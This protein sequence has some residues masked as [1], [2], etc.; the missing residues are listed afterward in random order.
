MTV[1]WLATSDALHQ[2]ALQ[3]TGEHITG[4]RE[5]QVSLLTIDE[6]IYQL[7]R[8]MIAR[9]FGH[10]TPKRINP[11]MVMKQNPTLLAAFRPQIHMAIS[12]LLAWGTLT[13]CAATA[14]QI[15]DSWLERFDDIGGL[16]DALHLSLAEHSGARSLATGDADFRSVKALP[17]VLQII[18]L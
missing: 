11:G 12:F 5:L 2:R 14:R 1:A 4:G 6:T 8:G 18:K 16:H 7:L 15:L 3:F 13:D 9:H 10:T 17:T